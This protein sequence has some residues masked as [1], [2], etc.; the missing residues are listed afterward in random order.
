M[1]PIARFFL[2]SYTKM[3]QYS[4]IVSYHDG[5][6]STNI[7]NTFRLSKKAACT[8]GIVFFIF[9][10][11]CHDLAMIMVKLAKSWLTMVPLSRSLQIM[12][13][14]TL[15]KIMAISWQDNYGKTCKLLLIV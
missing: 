7:K 8:E 5:Q 12:I 15:V 13:H 1:E 9:L 4:K 11:F 2:K 3:I 10:E 6:N 14:V